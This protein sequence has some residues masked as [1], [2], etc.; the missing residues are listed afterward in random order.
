MTTN[1]SRRIRD[2][3]WRQGRQVDRQD[4][5]DCM[6]LRQGKSSG[7]IIERIVIAR[8]F[9]GLELARIYAVLDC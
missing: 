6:A 5:A 9:G 8:C 4:R 1:K 2:G 3:T 7:Q